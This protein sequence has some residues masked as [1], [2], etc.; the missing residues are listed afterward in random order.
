MLAKKGE[1]KKK[2][3]YIEDVMKKDERIRKLCDKL[4]NAKSR[5]ETE[6]VFSKAIVAVLDNVAAFICGKCETTVPADCFLSHM[7][8]CPRERRVD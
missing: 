2:R 1:G 8:I 6:E 5:K 3:N 4:K 7:D